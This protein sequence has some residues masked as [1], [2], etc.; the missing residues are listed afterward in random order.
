MVNSSWFWFSFFWWKV[1]NIVIFYENFGEVILSK[2]RM[3]V[4][5]LVVGSVTVNIVS[6][7][8]F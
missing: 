7:Y 2:D 1:F 3:V 6:A 8:V 4:I 5:K